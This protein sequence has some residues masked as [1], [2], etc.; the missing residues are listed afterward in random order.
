VSEACIADE[1][2]DAAHVAR[3][4]ADDSASR[5]KLRSNVP[6]SPSVVDRADL[7]TIVYERA[8]ELLVK[9][10]QHIQA[11]G[12]LKNLVRGIVLTG[13]AASIKHYTDLAE[14]V[15]QVPCRVGVPTGVDILPSAVQGPEFSAAV[16]I[17]RHA[18][19]YRAAAA[20]GRIE[21][22]GSMVSV[23][24]RAARFLKRYFL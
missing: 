4:D 11:R 8:K 1:F 17:A 3:A 13:G 6:G 7:D 18:F 22:R 16:G 2:E 20:H 9:V 5:V 10:R 12:L 24:R 19:E 15:F 23:S 14:A 21:P